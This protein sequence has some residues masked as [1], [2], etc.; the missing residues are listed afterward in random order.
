M[1]LLDQIKHKIGT[2]MLASALKKVERRRKVFNIADA[3][4]VGILFEVM[5]EGNFG[6]VRYFVDY[7]QDQGKH[8][9]ALGYVESKEVFSFLRHTT[10]YS[11][12][13]KSEVNWYLKPDTVD[14]RNFVEEEF[15]IL[16]DLD[17][18]DRLPIKWIA[19]LSKAHF[20]VGRYD[21]E[22]QDFY[23]IMININNDRTLKYFIG[24][25][26]HY[27]TIINTKYEKA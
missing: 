25:I 3:R 26:K 20:K 15:D 17:V 23:D 11:F 5:D 10:V 27:L 1:K 12:F 22:K 7:L 9:K 4:N 8:V 6:H 13:H 14:S 19:G 18:L 21:E 2:W 16:I 24:Q